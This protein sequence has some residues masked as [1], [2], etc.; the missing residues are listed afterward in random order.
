MGKQFGSAAA[1]SGLNPARRASEAAL[2]LPD[3]KDQ[4]S[5]PS[6]FASPSRLVFPEHAHLGMVQRSIN[7]PVLRIVFASHTY[8]T[9][10]FRSL[11]RKV[12]LALAAC[13]RLQLKVWD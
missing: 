12:V 1:A 3:P 4:R 9:D 2:Q 7:A 13:F 10:L 8:N 6:V 5:G 11:P